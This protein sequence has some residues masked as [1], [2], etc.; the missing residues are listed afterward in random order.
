[1]TIP[2]LSA[3]DES[4]NTWRGILAADVAHRQA[5][6]REA[7]GPMLWPLY[8]FLR[9]E[10]RLRNPRAGHG[11]ELSFMAQQEPIALALGWSEAKLKQI[12]S[13]RYPGLKP[14]HVQAW[15]HLVAAKGW[16]AP[17]TTVRARDVG[18]NGKL[19]TRE[20]K[21]ETTAGMLR[22][23][24]GTIFIVR[25][26]MAPWTVKVRREHLEHNWR[27][28]DRDIR[29]GVTCRALLAPS[30]KS[31]QD[32]KLEVT[33]SKSKEEKTGYAVLNAIYLSSLTHLARSIEPDYLDGVTLPKASIN[34]V[35]NA[36]FGPVGCGLEGRSK[37]VVELANQISQIVPRD[38]GRREGFTNWIPR[39]RG[40]AWTVLKLQVNGFELEA[41]KARNII[42]D[43]LFGVLV[44]E[45]D[46]PNVRRPGA[47]FLARLKI[48]EDWQR[49][50]ALAGTLY[51]GRR[52]NA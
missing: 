5:D 6:V 48:S 35:Q 52:V 44:R 7:I 41:D 28:L 40:L 25:D 32:A 14:D 45:S 33:L 47:L 37:W 20:S 11:G 12:L 23:N 17:I 9:V 49:L 38:Q 8:N 3:S 42:W 26:R 51:A 1:M 27:D 2:S 19:R 50:E 34:T 39:Y 10:A 15:R 13:G 46:N 43:T 22:V 4:L 36:L 30:G 21:L 29:A 16:T 24:A 31:V 18:M